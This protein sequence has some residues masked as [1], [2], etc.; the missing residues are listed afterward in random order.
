MNL[1]G[2]LHRDFVHA[3]R[4]EVLASHLATSLPQGASILDVGAGDGLL[5]HVM[6]R[7]RPDITVQGI[8]TLVRPGT[9]IPVTE[10]DGL[11][12]PFANLSFDAVMLV[13]VIHHSS[14]PITL[15]RE[16]ARVSRKIV[17]IKDHNR[18]G[19]LAGPVLRFMDWISNARYGV[20]LPYNYWRRAVWRESFRQLGL[21]IRE[22]K[23]HLGLYPRLVRPVFER[24]LHFMVSLGTESFVRSNAPGG[25]PAPA[26]SGKVCCDTEWE[27]AYRSFETPEEEIGK[28]MRRLTT[29]GAAEWRRDA[30]IVELFCGRGNGLYALSRMG[31]CNLEGVDLSESLIARYTGGAKCYVADCRE[32]PFESASR[33]IVIIQGGLHHLDRLPD[34]LDRTLTEV[35]RVL[36]SDGLLVVVEPWLTPFLRLV[37]AA[38]GN[39]ALRRVYPK[40]EALATMIRHEQRTYDQWLAAPS[41]ILDAFTRHFEPKLRRRAW[42]KL[43]YIGGK[44]KAAAVTARSVA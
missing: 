39:A 26:D 34:D 10:F 14:D 25:T 21:S 29:L 38:C 2:R 15:L 30:R 28:F 11:R 24:H 1:I 5:A 13:D 36:K 35:S 7:K 17:L 12:I 8:D 33:D 42:G 22:Y 37:H 44:R 16:A 23:E 32:L 18:E 6:Y 31:F 4:V 27:A 43:L 9:H 20:S 40:L 19:L 3:R 41:S